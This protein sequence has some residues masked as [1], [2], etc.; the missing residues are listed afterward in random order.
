M[1]SRVCLITGGTRGL[2]RILSLSLLKKG[3]SVIVNYIKSDKEAEALRKAGCITFRADV[4]QYKECKVLADFV[5]ERFGTLYA[6]INNA[7]ITRDALLIKL[8]EEDWQR[9]I[10]V[11]LKGVFNTINLLSEF[12]RGG[13]I[14]NISS[15]SGI[16]GKAGQAAYSASKAGLIGLSLTAARELSEKGIKVNVVIPGYMETDMG[17]AS[18][19]AMNLAKEESLLKTLASP[20]EVAR[21]ISFLL[22]TET[23]TG[24]VFRLDSRI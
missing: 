23:I 20:H 16:R 5:R 2:G 21:F 1:N 18:P 24:Q 17:R 13:H 14:I 11:N 3:Y 10:D 6:L 4:S 9:V 7:A 8:R 22:E 19:Q 15:Y 12:L